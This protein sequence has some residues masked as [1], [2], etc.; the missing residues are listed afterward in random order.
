MM[1]TYMSIHDE[2]KFRCDEGR[3]FPFTLAGAD[4]ARWIFMSAEVNEL[5]TGPWENQEWKNRFTDL[6]VDFEQF[7]SGGIISVARNPRKAKRAYMSQLEKP[8]ERVW[9]IRSRDPSPG[10]RVVGRFA[11][12]DTFIALNW[13]LRCNLGEYGSDEW[14]YII[15]D[16][17]TKWRQLF[18]PYDALGN[19]E[20]ISEDNLN[21]YISSKA[22]PVGNL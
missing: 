17:K 7:V 18:Q 10:I 1:L 16:C 2:V 15:N 6:S 20:R 21:D 12:K 13:D 4:H 3:L 9:D 22:S 5:F 8:I 14:N 19:N 11:E